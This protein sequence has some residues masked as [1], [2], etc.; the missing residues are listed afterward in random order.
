M[1]LTK[2]EKIEWVGLILKR[3]YRREG[4]HRPVD[5]AYL[6]EM[7]LLPV[8]EVRAELAK[9]KNAELA[10][11]NAEISALQARKQELEGKNA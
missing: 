7:S 2:N 9:E 4:F 1:A 10:Q 8:E 11:I 3:Y 5:P 6:D